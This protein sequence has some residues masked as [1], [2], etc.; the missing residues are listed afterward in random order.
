MHMKKHPKVFLTCTQRPYGKIHGTALRLSMN[1]ST[2][3]HAEYAHNRLLPVVSLV[4]CL[5]LPD[6]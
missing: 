3:G 2:A 4:P 5:Y 1:I 6:S